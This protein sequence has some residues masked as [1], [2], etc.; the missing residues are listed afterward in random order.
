MKIRIFAIHV[1]FGN[2]TLVKLFDIDG[3]FV[4]VYPTERQSKTTIFELIYLDGYAVSERVFNGYKRMC[5]DIKNFG[6]EV[7]IADSI[8]RLAFGECVESESV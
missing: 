2:E 1:H 5:E 8:E 7:A 4:G 3:R 6:L